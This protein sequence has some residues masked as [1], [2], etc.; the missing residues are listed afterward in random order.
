MDPAGPIDPLICPLCGAANDCARAGERDEPGGAPARACWC[1][2]A[3][4][5]ADLIA[6]VP[7]PALG[8]ACICRSC[9]AAHRPA[10]R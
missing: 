5:G 6:R 7:A 8:R 1:V 9:A 10:G 2:D 3:R 4:F